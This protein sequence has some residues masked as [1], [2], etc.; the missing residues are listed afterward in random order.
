MKTLDTEL[1]PTKNNF[2]LGINNL[3]KDKEVWIQGNAIMVNV[4]YVSDFYLPAVM[5]EI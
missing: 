2:K 4:D 5:N 3:S 1:S